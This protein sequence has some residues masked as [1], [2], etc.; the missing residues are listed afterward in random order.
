MFTNLRE[1][2]NWSE[3]VYPDPENNYGFIYTI[4]NV[5]DGKI[6]IG[7]K[8]YK[9]KGRKYKNTVH[10]LK[11]GWEK[12]T[13]SSKY[14][15]DDIQKYGKEHFV[16]SI[17][18]NVKTEEELVETELYYLRLLDVL[19]KPD[20]F[21]NRNIGGVYKASECKMPNR[22]GSNNSMYGKN[23]TEESRRK[24]GEASKG[25]KWS[26]DTR[27]KKKE[28]SELNKKV[29]LFKNDDGREMIGTIDEV[30]NKY[31]EKRCNFSELIRGRRVDKTCVSGYTNVIKRNGWS[32]PILLG[33][34]K[35]IEEI[36]KKNINELDI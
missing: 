34:K 11:S 2:I 36:L 35:D 24:I 23:H 19:N 26:E 18:A 9:Y 10:T 4:V 22:S 12:Y 30:C 27:L 17:L 7:R 31:S 25:R 1:D 5:I 28:A 16:F 32:R 15:N 3:G 33:V 29:Y 13:S 6:Y 8:A 14:L 21:Y 20:I